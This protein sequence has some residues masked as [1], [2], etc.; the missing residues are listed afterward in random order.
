MEVGAVM[1]M[2]GASLYACS[3]TS[4]QIP[5]STPKMSD[6]NKFLKER[7][8]E[9]KETSPDITTNERFKII[10]IEWKMKKEGF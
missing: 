4:Q 2:T 8:K 6:Y 9:I 1:M 7:F 5:I 10:N 3:S